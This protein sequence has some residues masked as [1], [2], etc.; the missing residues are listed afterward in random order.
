MDGA[1]IAFPAAFSIMWI[2]LVVWFV[3]YGQP[4]PQNAE[5]GEGY[6]EYTLPSDYFE[7]LSVTNGHGGGLVV[8]YLTKDG[9]LKA[10]QYSSAGGRTSTWEF[11]FSTQK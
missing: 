7:P 1:R 9:K 11:S 2:V 4:S 6:T 5:A 3:V 10:I 8:G